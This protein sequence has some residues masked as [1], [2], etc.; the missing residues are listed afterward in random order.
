[1][2]EF[3]QYLQLYEI[4][5]VRLSIEARVRYLTVYNAKK[6][7]P[8]MSENAQKIKEAVFRLTGMPY[9]GSFV[10]IE[11]NDKPFALFHV[12]HLPKNQQHS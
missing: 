3:E 11:M 5:P 7:N 4:D 12:K 8:I 9:T 1:M 6:G 10:L 2:N